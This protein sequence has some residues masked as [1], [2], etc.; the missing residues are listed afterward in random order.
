MSR[1]L[2]CF[3]SLRARDEMAL[4]C[5]LTAG[6]PDAERSIEYI[7]ACLRGGADLIEIGVPFSDPVADGPVIQATTEAALRGGMRPKKVLELLTQV[8]SGTDAPIVLMGYY[9]PIFRMGEERFA[10][11]AASSGADGL[12]VPDLPYEES[13][14][15]RRSCRKNDLDLIQLVAPT[16]EEARMSE[17][18]SASSGY[19]YLVSRLG[20]TGTAHGPGG[21]IGEL[22][23]RT[24]LCSN[25]LP[26]A[27]GFGISKPEQVAKLRIDGADGAI[28]GSGILKRIMD[29]ESPDGIASFVR[30]LKAASR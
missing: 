11:R 15:L 13:K 25:G 17:I 22:V 5:Y 26:V 12:I 7:H 4:V 28:V 2:S 6:Y 10:Q 30:S 24:K 18:A 23:R 20:I 9:N 14:T 16:T 19:L 27:V 3:G 21:D 29:G 8:R 1:I